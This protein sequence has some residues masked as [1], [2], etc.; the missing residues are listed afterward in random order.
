M[1]KNLT[2]VFDKAFDNAVQIQ[3]ATGNGVAF[4]WAIC[5]WARK[6]AGFTDEQLQAEHQNLR[7]WGGSTD[8]DAQS[9]IKNIPKDLW[10]TVRHSDELGINGNPEPKT[11]IV[12][13]NR[14]EYKVSVKMAGAVQLASG[15]GKSSSVTIQR[16]LD[17]YYAEGNVTSETMAMIVDKIANMP[18]KMLD[19]KNLAKAKAQATNNYNALTNDAGEILPG[20]DWEQFKEN[21]KPLILDALRTYVANHPRFLHILVDEALTGRRSF[22]E[23]SLATANYMITPKKLQAIDSA[24]GDSVVPK[25]KIDL[26]A[27]SRSGITS[28]TM[29]FDYKAEGWLGNIFNKIKNKLKSFLQ[30][31]IYVLFKGAGEMNVTIPI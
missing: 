25:V 11:D 9:A 17:E 8:K 14:N 13:G 23:N 7:P 4:E 28:A 15:E 31:Y 12:F 29:R 19:K 1:K 18:T 26:R 6:G 20:Y 22:G 24:Y 27:K 2:E 3:E 10:G 5:Y 16:A 21:N 30:D